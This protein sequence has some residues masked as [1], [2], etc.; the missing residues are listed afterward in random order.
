MADNTEEE[1]LDN[2][3]SFQTENIPEDII[4][5]PVKATL[6]QNQET[7]TIEVHKHPHHITHKKKWAEYL[8]EFFMLFLAV[9]LGFIAEN[10]REN[11]VEREREKEYAR[12]LLF[13]LKADSAALSTRKTQFER[14]T[15]KHRRFVA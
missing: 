7:E 15:M 12:L 4:A 14:L 2:P 13:D 6:L 5:I 8:L 1:H 9:F 10:I 11:N 3:P